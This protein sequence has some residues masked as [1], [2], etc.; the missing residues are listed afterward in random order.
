MKKAP[1]FAE[2]PRPIIRYNAQLQPA[3]QTALRKDIE[4]WFAMQGQNTKGI[5]YTMK[6]CEKIF[7]TGADGM[8]GSS[9]CRELVRQGYS[10]KGMILPN[11]NLN[12]LSNLNIEIVEGNIL[13]KDILQK[14]MN[15]CDFVIHA[16]ASTTVWP[17]RSKMVM[18][19]NFEGTK[20]IVEVA[21]KINVKRMVH[22]GTAN[23]FGH[24]P[25]E[26]PGDETTSFAFGKYGLDYIDSKYI[27]QKMLLEKYSKDG[28]P[29]IIINPT[30]MIGSFDSGPS[31]GKMIIELLKDRMPGYSVGGKNFIAATDVAVAAVNALKIGR[32]GECYIAGNENLEYKEFFKKVCA[33]RNKKF[34]L[35]K[36]PG[37]LL[38]C[39]GLFNSVVARLI[40]KAPRLSY[41]MSRMAKV[42]QYYS[43][44][45][46]QKELNLPQTPIEKGI[47]MC[48]D[49]FELNGYLK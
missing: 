46:A 1:F 12:V 41:S 19:V 49:W 32:L 27:S 24:G 15:T 11:R 45:K 3:F 6:N 25:K 28:F 39:I 31:S 48:I 8:L 10:V 17:R 47:E 35:I 4:A 13:D 44:K 5:L 23:S 9:I 30:Y 29:I 22:I 14:E 21:E 34:N 40:H 26:K 18:S 37:F 7:V 20:N 43:S 38:L 36:V 2:S 33:V 16:A 42:G